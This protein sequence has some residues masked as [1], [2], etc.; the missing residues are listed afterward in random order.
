MLNCR[1]YYYIQSPGQNLSGPYNCSTSKSQCETN[2]L[3]IIQQCFNFYIR[4]TLIDMHYQ[5]LMR[6]LPLFPLA[7]CMSVLHILSCMLL[8][9]YVAGDST[10][11]ENKETG[12]VATDQSCLYLVQFC[13]LSSCVQDIQLVLLYVQA[14]SPEGLTPQG[15]DGEQLVPDHPNEDQ[16]AVESVNLTSFAYQIA[17][18]MV[19]PLFKPNLQSRLK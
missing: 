14:Q 2:A 7:T 11:A 10:T 16:G 12:D 1:S 3:I 13:L 8:T 9:L 15:L 6:A 17:S 4:I 5:V 19:N 18:G